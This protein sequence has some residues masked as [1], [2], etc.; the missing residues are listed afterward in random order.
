MMAALLAL[1]MLLSMAAMTI[2]LLS[3]N[4]YAS[5]ITPYYTEDGKDILIAAG[6]MYADGVT[7]GFETRAANGFTA[8]SLDADRHFTPLYT[9]NSNSVSVTCDINL[10]K[11]G[12]SYYISTQTAPAVGGW[13]IETTANADAFALFDLCESIAAQLNYNVF[14]AVINGHTKIRIGQFGSHAEAETASAAFS[15]QGI[16][17]IIAAPSVT[18]VSV[19][20]PY[21][22]KILF[23]FDGGTES[24]LGLKPVQTSEETVYLVTPAKNTYG[25]IFKYSRWRTGNIDGIAVT[26]ILPL[27]E[28]VEGV[29]PWEVGNGWAQEVL[30]TFAIAARSY[31]LSSRKHE[32]FDLCNS[33]C[34]Q[35]YRGRNRTNA[36]V[37]EA[38]RETAGIVLTYENKIVCTYY[39]SSTGGT[40]ISASDAWG[41]TEKYPYLRAVV[42]PWEKYTTYPNASWKAEL[43]SAQL[44]AKLNAFGY[45]TLSGGIK[46]LEILSYAENS[47]YVKSLKIT[48]IKGVSVT[49]NRSDSI[50]SALGI[51]SANF[52]VAKAGEIVVITDYSLEDDG[53]ATLFENQPVTEI[54]N[55]TLSVKGGVYVLSDDNITASMIPVGE[56][57][58]LTTEMGMDISFKLDDLSVITENGIQAFNMIETD[59]LIYPGEETTITP[60]SANLPDLAAVNVIKTQRTVTAEGNP[61]SFVFIGRG[62]G[63]GVGLSQYGAKALADMGY[64]HETILKTYF[65]GT[66]TSNYSLIIMKQTNPVS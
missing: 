31:A 66:V 57:I 49:I 46:S 7:V 5:D 35:A 1:L 27:E 60:P 48:D 44:L 28:Y 14:Q 62:W 63:H 45:S 19:I 21:T 8:G 30:R 17:V 22:D 42:T 33:T 54:P 29:L 11:T 25:G 43:T 40:T 36:A 12:M 52:V 4:A 9:I 24:T 58:A 6:L 10:A 64:D 37:M 50:R 47:S 61:G 20:D 15:S 23:E 32:T 51:N 26:N 13:H 41:Y 3:M 38:V 18:A 53:I 55:D 2:Q 56:S 59:S 34:C 65:P 39:S 16:E